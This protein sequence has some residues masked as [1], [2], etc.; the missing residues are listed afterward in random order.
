VSAPLQAP[1]VAESALAALLRTAGAAAGSLQ[2]GA[3]LQARVV[4]VTE[5]GMYLVNLGGQLRLVESATALKVGDAFRVRVVAVAD[6]VEMQRVGDVRSLE[7]GAPAES[8]SNPMTQTSV[9]GQ[10]SLAEAAA[11][12]GQSVRLAASERARVAEHI[13]RAAEPRGHAT[14][15]TFLARSSISGARELAPVLAEMIRRDKRGLPIAATLALSWESHASDGE[16]A[17]APRAEQLQAMAIQI[18]KASRLPPLVPG[19]V[20]GV[21]GHRTEG[22]AAGSGVRADLALA[23]ILNAQRGGAVSH[24]LSAIDIETPAGTL[25]LDMALFEQCEPEPAERTIRHRRF[26]LTIA[27]PSVGELQIDA[28]VEA[29]GVDLVFTHSTAASAERMRSADERLRADL[30]ALGWRAQCI[31]HRLAEA[32]HT[33]E[34][35]IA[36]PVQFVIEQALREGRLDAKI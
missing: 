10:L 5:G 9:R 32:Q 3:L 17:A 29:E 16:G 23:H 27:L 15:L 31:E 12:A 1:A 25:P 4:R 7:R 36:G 13:R 24:R 35:S 19:K 11:A 18:D 21:G 6:R 20:K 8:T 28:R 30:D 2:A 14:A 33:D 26:S 34:A 22:I